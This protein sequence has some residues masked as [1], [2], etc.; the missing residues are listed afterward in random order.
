V[1]VHEGDAV[2]GG[3]AGLLVQH[4]GV[5]AALVIDYQLADQR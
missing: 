4:A 2:L 3:L 1:D 5:G